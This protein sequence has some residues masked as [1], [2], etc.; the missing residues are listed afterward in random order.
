MDDPA[1]GTSGPLISEEKTRVPRKPEILPAGDPILGQ[2]VTF[3]SRICPF[4]VWGNT[5]RLNALPVS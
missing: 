4:L 1:L 3:G 2:M 5:N